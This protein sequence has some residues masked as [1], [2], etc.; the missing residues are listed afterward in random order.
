MLISRGRTVKIEDLGKAPLARVLSECMASRLTG[1]VD[2]VLTTEGERYRIQVEFLGGEP[3]LALTINLRTGDAYYGSEA[4]KMIKGVITTRE[5]TGY[6]EVI[7]LS[8]GKVAIDCRYARNA[9]LPEDSVK[10]LTELVEAVSAGR[11]EAPPHPPEAGPTLTPPERVVVKLSTV[12]CDLLKLVKLATEG[13]VIEARNFSSV[14]E[15]LEAGRALA[16]SLKGEGEMLYAALSLRDAR[17]R[18]LYDRSGNVVSASLERS[19]EVV[20]GFDVVDELQG[21]K[22]GVR[23]VYSSIPKHALQE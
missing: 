21:V 12:L 19:G 15:A 14:A 20:C 3:R 13:R 8:E 18:V 4:V 5:C 2:A 9:Q 6:A 11:A 22:G 16:R 10:E 1:R 7:E 23:A 17:L